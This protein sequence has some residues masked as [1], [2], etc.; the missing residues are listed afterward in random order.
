[1]VLLFYLIAMILF[2]RYENLFIKWKKYHCVSFF[3]YDKQILNNNKILIS[4]AKTLKN[5]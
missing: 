4:Y 2:L 5:Q 1:M 3:N